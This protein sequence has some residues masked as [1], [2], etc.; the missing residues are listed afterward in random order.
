[1]LELKPSGSSGVSV[2]ANGESIRLSEN[3]LGRWVGKESSL[4]V[5]SLP[6]GSAVLYLPRE[7]I[8]LIYDGPRVQL[9]VRHS[10]MYRT[11]GLAGTFDG[12]ETTDFS[13]P[14]N[15]ILSKPLEFAATYALTDSQC[16][17]PAKERK[18]QA[19][20][21]P[22]FEKYFLS[23]KVVSDYEAG[24]GKQA[25]SLNSAKM[26]RNQM[27][28]P[29][30]CEQLRTQTFEENGRTCFSTRPQLTCNSH[31][32]A[33]KK[34]QKTVDYHC[35]QASSATKHWAQMVKK[36]ANPDFTQKSV[37]RQIS[38]SLPES[39]QPKA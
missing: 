11:R 21:S 9:S 39:C 31:C 2:Q 37:D 13:A 26:S 4:E 5:Y 18:Q 17:G 38:L 16:Q 6:D 1:M 24:R 20:S 23:G 15:R 19:Q 7:G 36:G 28:T 3:K 33:T 25:Q 22:S 29:K 27:R 8:Q 30:S 12:E 10:Y 14:N 35:M 32:K 34:I